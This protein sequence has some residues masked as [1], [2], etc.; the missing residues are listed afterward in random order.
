MKLNDF[1]QKTNLDDSLLIGYYGGGNYGDELLLE[2]LCNLLANRGVQNLKITYQRPNTY[3]SMHRNFGSELVDIHNRKSVTRAAIRSKN[4]LIG[5]GGLW[6]VDMNFNT[7]LLSIF[8]FV[9]RWA[10]RKKVYLLGVGYYNSTTWMGRLGAWF[11]GKAANVIIARDA[12]TAQNFSRVNKHVYQDTDIAWYTKDVDL[13]HYLDNVEQMQKHLPV[14]D[15]TLLVAL[16]R[17]QSKRQ[18]HDFIRFNK[19]IRW[20][21]QSNPTRPI[22]LLMLESE[23][24]DSGLYKE[25]RSLRRSHKHLRIIEAPY[26]PLTLFSFVKKNYHRLALIAPQLHMIMTAH[27]AGVPFMPITYDNKVSQL[28]DQIG[29]PLKERLQIKEVSGGDLLEYANDFYGGKK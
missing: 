17:P 28:L 12:E 14:G 11:A 22:I 4:I 26:N 20:L 5:G 1:L 27:L 7:L 23:A 2:V 10:L 13:T 15:K 19:L 16:R 25:A 29:V 9:S 6:G 24:K 21:V 3:Q 18:H 8:L